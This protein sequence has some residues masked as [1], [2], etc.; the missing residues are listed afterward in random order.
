[1]QFMDIPPIFVIAAIVQQISRPVKG[2]SESGEEIDVYRS[3]ALHRKIV[4]P[5]RGEAPTWESPAPKY[6][7]IRTN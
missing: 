6:E 7:D 5:R 2:F 1:M 4:I 3:L